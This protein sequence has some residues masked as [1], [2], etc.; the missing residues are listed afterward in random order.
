MDE[1]R[2]MK[3][4]ESETKNK[5]EVLA[6]LFESSNPKAFA[7]RFKAAEEDWK[8]PAKFIQQVAS[9]IPLKLYERFY[10]DFVPHGFFGLSCAASTLHLFP[11]ERRWWPCV[12]QAWFI[13]R[14]RRRRAWDG[15]P[16][17]IVAPASEEEGWSQFQTASSSRDFKRCFALLRGFLED[18][19]QRDFFRT[20]SLT[21]ALLDTA[22][23]GLKFIQLAKAWEMAEIQDWNEA[24]QILFPAFH[25]MVLGPCRDELATRV[26]AAG[27]LEIPDPEKDPVSKADLQRLENV[28]LC[29][30]D[31]RA[32]LDAL[33]RLAGQGHGFASI[34]EALLLVAAQALNNAQMGRWLPPLRAFLYTDACLV[35]AQGVPAGEKG[36]GLALAALLIQQASGRSRES[37]ESR[38]VVEPVES[39]CPTN[40]F[41]TLRSLVSH[42]DP[43][44]SAN[45]VRA[46][47]GMGAEA[48]GELTQTL[49]T[50]AAKN[51]A[52]VGQ[53]YDLLLVQ[54]CS[55]AYER[56]SSEMRDWFLV[57]CG[58][59][60][61]RILKNYELFGAYGVK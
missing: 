42:S 2:E 6:E 21:R 9:S 10:D 51:D 47:L 58:F 44:A 20:Q 12:Q 28:I 4:P 33:A 50:L 49:A 34:H 27:Q 19:S 56:S 5:E 45:T 11:E 60:L 23:G 36:R 46:I 57:C 48:C 26:A 1:Q 15:A 59:F 61:G 3:N 39:V 41:V 35:W 8:E 32:S 22:H 52:R 13:A 37:R 7:K 31:S 54:A 40:P 18:P 43:Y 55:A 16:A 25:F 29:S 17:D 38:V 14:A 24:H 30:D 53:G